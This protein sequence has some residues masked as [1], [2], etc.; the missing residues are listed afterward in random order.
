MMICSNCSSNQS[1]KVKGELYCLNCGHRLAAGAKGDVVRPKATK[2][3]PS[4][5]VAA[6]GHAHVAVKSPRSQ[7][8]PIE[9]TVAW[10][11][12][13]QAM[14]TRP[15]RTVGWVAALLATLIAAL[16]TTAIGGLTGSLSHFTRTTA[17][18]W[19][20]PIVLAV[21]LTWL[22]LL[23]LRA[24]A[25]YSHSH[26][27]DRRPVKWSSAL[28]AGWNSVGSL[29]GLDAV[30]LTTA[31]LWVAALIVAIRAIDG[32]AL[33]PTAQTAIGIAACLVM[34]LAG[35]TLVAF[36]NFA[37]QLIT[38]GDLGLGRAIVKAA[39]VTRRTFGA[40][41]G[42]VV[43]LLVI[44]AIPV[45]AAITIWLSPHW[46][47]LSPALADWLAATVAVVALRYYL[48]LTQITWLVAYRRIIRAH[49]SHQLAVY[50][51]RRPRPVH[52][53]AITVTLIWWVAFAGLASWWLW[54]I[55]YD[56]TPLL[57]R[58]HLARLK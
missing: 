10:R 4:R 9:L 5:P 20:P 42:L 47:A 31:A 14:A 6:V 21:I 51:G 3:E 58:L 44:L 2:V 1:I 13:A 50:L 55:H 43:W 18:I 12:S 30:G 19:L 57:D 15:L 16:A 36:Y 41:I 23:W 27:L 11:A 45:A 7:S 8:L 37:V 54:R 40:A 24:S 49:G 17:V 52:A 46:T 32:L 26:R 25:T 28:L 22:G 48:S 53:L 33:G 35:L 29:A 39:V 38:L 56:P 34:A